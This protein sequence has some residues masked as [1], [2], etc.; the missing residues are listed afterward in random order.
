VALVAGG[1]TF[2]GGPPTRTVLVDYSPDEFSANFTDYFPS[3]IAVRQGDTVVFK[4]TW[5]GEPHSVT[6]GALANKL[7]EVVKPALKIFE[8]K[9]YAGLGPEPAAAVALDKQIPYMFTNN[10]KVAQNGAQPC[11]LDTGLPPHDPNKA[12]TRTQ[13]QQPNFTGRQNWYNSGYI[14]Y[15]G[16]TGNTF[17]VKISP[18][19]TPGSYFFFCNNHGPFMS[20]FLDIKPKA[21]KV[22]SQDAVNRQAQQEINRHLALLRSDY[23]LAQEGRFPVPP[24]RVAVV[25]KAGVQTADVGGRTIVRSW[26]AGLPHDGLDDASIIEF[27]PKTAHAR[28]GEKVSWLLVGG[29]NQGHTISFDVPQY[30]PIFTIKP[31]GTVIRNPQL[32]QPAGG[33]PPLP[34]D[35]QS[36]GSNNHGPPPKPAV[37]DGGAWD[38]GKFFSSGLISPGTFTLYSLRF[39]KA[40]TYKF[41]C[42]VHPQMVGTLVVTP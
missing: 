21:S 16:P 4:Q 6:M 3:H 24:E 40:G 23:Q 27:V 5:T 20:G 25:K 15:A 32:D 39:S 30:L 13:Q 12:C 41:A 31:D 35:A 19:A 38:G 29:A 1:C 2:G 10:G 22:P 7:G 42:L 33:A 34:P 28:I 11:Y 14:H 8:E 37:I 26:F 9:G 36:G 18:N 17:R